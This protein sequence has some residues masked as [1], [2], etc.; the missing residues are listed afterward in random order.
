MEQNISCCNGCENVSGEKLDAEWNVWF[1]S[2][3]GGGLYKSV[4][5]S[6][7]D[8]AA[9]VWTGKDKIY[10]VTH[11]KTG[12]VLKTK[13]YN[14]DEK[15]TKELMNVAISVRFMNPLTLVD[16]GSK[17]NGRLRNR[18]SNGFPILII[19]RCSFLEFVEI[20]QEC[21]FSFSGRR[22]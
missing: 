11:I 20:I 2:T 16:W 21:G 5:S 12:L 3:G 13:D 7:L 19:E 22:S 10:Q 1:S 14:T 6:C 9:R 17:Y 8:S 15:Q 4:C 18:T